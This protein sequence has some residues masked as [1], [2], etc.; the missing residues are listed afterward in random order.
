MLQAQR[1]GLAKGHLGIK[2][3]CTLLQLDIFD[4]NFSF[5]QKAFLHDK[6]Y[7]S[8]AFLK[9]GE[10]REVFCSFLVHKSYFN[11]KLFFCEAQNQI[12]QPPAPGTRSL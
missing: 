10:V 7:Y 5:I 9:L 6:N 1:D 2:L 4:H 11:L 12:D 8:R 3:V